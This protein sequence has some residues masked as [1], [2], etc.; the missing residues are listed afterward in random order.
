MPPPDVYGDGEYEVLKF[1]GAP[2]QIN[3]KADEPEWKGATLWMNTVAHVEKG[4]DAWR[5]PEDASAEWIFRWVDGAM[6]FLVRVRDDQVVAG[7][8][9]ASNDALVVGPAVLTLAPLGKVSAS[10]APQATCAWAEAP[11]G[12]RMECSIPLKELQLGAPSASW[13]QGLQLK[14]SD[15]PGESPTVLGSRLRGRA[16]KTYPPPWEEL[17]PMLQPP[18]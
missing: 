2:P 11:K 17:L 7:G 10:G 8:S 13:E 4:D 14:D 18:W 3:G 12:Y 5:G 16:W 1:K 9:A 6:V 15:K